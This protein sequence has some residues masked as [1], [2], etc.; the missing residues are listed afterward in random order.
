MML[1]TVCGLVLLALTTAVTPSMAA[2]PIGRPP[3]ASGGKD[4]Q[5]RQFT[6]Y[7][8]LWHGEAEVEA[9]LRRY[10][11]ERRLPFKFVVR[12]VGR[13]LS[14]VPAIVREIKERKPDLVYTWGTDVTLKVVGDVG[15]TPR[16]G[17]V[18]RIPV[19]FSMV[20]YPAG[21][22]IVPSLDGSGRNVASS[23]DFV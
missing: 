9:G 12:D 18:T 8:V 16:D 4:A 10:V 19:V 21:S 13:D 3:D 5:V 6:I 20:A 2:D 15:A 22:R 17:F 23:G 14:K 7:L 1:R 11:S